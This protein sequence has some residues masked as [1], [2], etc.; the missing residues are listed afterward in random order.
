MILT[1]HEYERAL[2][3]MIE[4]LPS[5]SYSH[6]IGI[7]RSGLIPAVHVAHILGISS[8]GMIAIRRTLSDAANVEKVEPQVGLMAVPEHM[9]GTN[10]L[11]VD[12]IVGEGKSVTRAKAE[13]DRFGGNVTTCSLVVNLANLRSGLPED[14]LDAFGLLVREWV[15]F[16]W[17]Q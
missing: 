5:R 16:P 10:I 1:W 7:S 8:F 9:L 15:V 12:D 17:C 6:V 14:V 2:R 4:R 13:L 3:T 11:L